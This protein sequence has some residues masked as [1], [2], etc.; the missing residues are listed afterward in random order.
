[1]KILITGGSSLLGRYLAQ[2][3]PD[4]VDIESTWYTNHADGVNYHLDIGNKS[5]VCYVFE[6]VKPD[7]I[8]HCA[9]EGSVDQ[10]EKHYR[11]V[12]AVN[13]TGTENVLALAREYGAKMVYIST[14]AVYDGKHGPYG[15][16]AP[17]APVNN[18]GRIKRAAE[19]AV[20][21]SGVPFLII[22]PFLLY[23]WPYENGRKNWG[24]LI[25]NKLR[26]GLSLTLVNDVIWQPTYAAD[27]AAFIWQVLD[28]EGAYNVAS[29]CRL[30]LYEFGLKVAEVFKLDAGLISPVS[31]NYFPDMAPRPKDTSYDLSG[32]LADG[33]GLPPLEDGLQRFKDE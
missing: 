29:E 16:L 12:L 1:M 26:Q 10:A 25:V 3:K 5:Q 22:R 32:L 28:R 17:Q 24:T 7:V 8:I 31:S 11:D 2:T 27:V 13:V 21:G 15:P 6:R 33:L 23:G 30:T 4:D 18:Y 20:I 19:V 14:N 9:A